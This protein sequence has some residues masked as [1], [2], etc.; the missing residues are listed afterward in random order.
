MWS[1]RRPLEAAHPPVVP[2]GHGEKYGSLVYPAPRHTQSELGLDGRSFAVK[3]LVNLRRRTV[4]G[5]DRS[6]CRAHI[7]EEAAA[8]VDANGCIDDRLQGMPERTPSCCPEG[9]IEPA[10]SA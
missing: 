8:R 9:T 7:D 6:S 5:L 4:V 2:A 10:V 1:W 3:R